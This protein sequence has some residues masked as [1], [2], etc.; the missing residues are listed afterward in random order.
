MRSYI[1]RRHEREGR[2]SPEEVSELV[3]GPLT[4]DVIK[5]IEENNLRAVVE[6]MV[7]RSKRR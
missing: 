3:K 4:P 5:K 6:V 2:L 7:E 1:R